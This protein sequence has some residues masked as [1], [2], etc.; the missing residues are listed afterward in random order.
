MSTATT[1]KLVTI[2]TES[3]LEH[4]LVDDFGRLGARGYTI[5]NARGKGHRGVRDADWS[6]SSNIRVEVICGE[7]VAETIVAYLQ[8]HYYKDYAMIIFMTDV[9]VM[10]SKKF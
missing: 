2:I 5:T 1:R 4:N 7:Q 10:R 6:T 3:A 9:E 8:K